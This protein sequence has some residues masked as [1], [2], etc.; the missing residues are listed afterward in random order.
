MHALF[1]SYLVAVIVGG[2]FFV[3]W[4]RTYPLMNIANA[5][6]ISSHILQPLHLE[7]RL[8]AIMRCPRWFLSFPIT[9]HPLGQINV[10]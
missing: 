10:Q 8:N 1:L 7:F 4:T 6:Q 9:R 3:A 5:G 2:T